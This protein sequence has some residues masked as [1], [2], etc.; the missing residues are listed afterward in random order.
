[1]GKATNR[2]QRETASENAPTPEQQA[3]AAFVRAGMAYRRIPPIDIMAADGKLS[4]RQHKAL[5]RY[6]DL[7]IACERSEIRDSCDMT[8]RGG[9]DG[10]GAAYLRARSDLRWLESELGGLRDIAQFV[11]GQDN[12]LSQWAMHHYGVKVREGRAP[13][14]TERGLK[15]SLLDLRMAGE[16]LAAAIAS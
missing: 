6:R 3:R 10:P 1:M 12:S 13:D 8:P 9:G 2:K 4:E 11:A 15:L 14:A 7:F 16:R 5:A